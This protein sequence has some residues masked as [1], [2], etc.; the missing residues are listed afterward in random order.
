MLGFM[1]ALTL[2]G[3]ADTQPPAAPGPAS[4]RRWRGSAR[5]RC[6][7]CRYELS[8]RCRPT[9]RQPS[10]AA[11]IARFSLSSARTRGLRLRPAA[12]AADVRSRRWPRRLYHRSR[13]PHR[14]PRRDDQGRRQ[15]DRDRLRGRRRGAQPERRVSLHALRPGARPP[16]VSRAS[17][18][19]ISRRAIA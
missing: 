7:T 8:C 2:L 17:T 14:H 16:H 12:R 4:P 19:R 15:R 3:S 5:R 1:V 9:G 11:S 18:S 13:R 10:P 6:G